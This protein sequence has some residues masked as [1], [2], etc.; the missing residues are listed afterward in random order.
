[1]GSMTFGDQVKVLDVPLA[2]EIDLQERAKTSL[3]TDK[4]QWT[5]SD[6]RRVE[7]TDGSKVR[8]LYPGQIF[9][10]AHSMVDGQTQVFYLVCE[11][12]IEDFKIIKEEIQITPSEIQQL[13]YE[14]TNRDYKDDII[15]SVNWRSTNANIADVDNNGVVYGKSPGAVTIIGTTIDGKIED[16][17]KIIVKS[18]YSGLERDIESPL[19][20]PVG[21]ER[22]INIY[23]K[24][25]GDSVEI[26]NWSSENPK[27][28]LVDDMGN[29]KG[30]K[31]GN[32][33]IKVYDP[34]SGYTE[35]IDVSVNSV[36]KDIDLDKKSIELNTQSPQAKLNVRF[37]KWN[38][39]DEILEDTVMWKSSDSNVVT[40]N[41]EGEITAVSNGTVRVVAETRDG[42]RTDYCLVTVRLE[43][44]SN[45]QGMLNNAKLGDMP[46]KV[47]NGNTFKVKIIDNKNPIDW[48][49]LKVSILKGDSDQ[50]L[51]QDDGI[52]VTP[53]ADTVNE[54]SIKDGSGNHIVWKFWSRSA[55]NR[56]EIDKST[57]PA[58]RNGYPAMFVGQT[59]NL[60]YKLHEAAWAKKSDIVMK[61]VKWSTDNTDVAFFPEDKEGTIKALKEGEF[62]VEVITDDAGR[63]DKVRMIVVPMITKIKLPEK[64]SIQVG[65]TYAPEI[66]YRVVAGH[67]T[68]FNK[69]IEFEVL[70]SVISDTYLQEEEKYEVELIDKLAALESNQT[71][72]NEIYQ[73]EVRLDKIRNMREYASDGYAPLE[74]NFTDRFGQTVN[75]VAFDKNKIIGQTP[76]KSYV[77]VITVD[78]EKEDIMQIVVD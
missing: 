37:I 20:L 68:P 24:P 43:D 42:S 77:K 52:Y 50:V 34:V 47:V 74:S 33:R 53:T 64:A 49:A 11:S 62:T 9:L 41:N 78:N 60:G 44:T 40:V 30:L 59:W 65:Q 2:Q 72:R 32:T 18:E 19:S 1:M 75:V 21:G 14:I 5:K 13:N 66:D 69:D 16:N 58:L 4:I 10:Y 7:V 17:V 70:N 27:I 45:A 28:A 12:A 67:K 22:T 3:G 15:E 38:D 57:L 25:T 73:H 23:R 63:T 29:V 31:A 26:G 8:F 61:S 51:V 46:Y 36:I 6:N 54:L 55:L 56:V 39:E 48:K 76:G 71:V 35:S